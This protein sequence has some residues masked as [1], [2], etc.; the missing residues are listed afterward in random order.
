M[1]CRREGPSEGP[2]RTVVSAGRRVVTICL[3]RGSRPSEG[4]RGACCFFVQTPGP[5]KLESGSVCLGRGL[6]PVKAECVGDGSCPPRMG[7]CP[8]GDGG[9]SHRPCLLRVSASPLPVTFPVFSPVLASV[10]TCVT[11]SRGAVPP[12]M[13]IWPRI[14]HLCARPAAAGG[15][16]EAGSRGTVTGGCNQEKHPVSPSQPQPLPSLFPR[17]KGRGGGGRGVQDLSCLLAAVHQR[18]AGRPPAAAGPQALSAG[19]ARPLLPVPGSFWR[20]TCNTETRVPL[21]QEGTVCVCD[22]SSLGASGQLRRRMGTNVCFSVS[23]SFFFF[24]I[25]FY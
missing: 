11:V 10:G 7:G 18:E 8:G 22:L 12:S 3:P 15:E 6:G 17:G 5:G 9:S 24:K 23:S 25:R 20:R 19:L 14:P 1:G 2:G 13:V 16:V 4:H 21:G